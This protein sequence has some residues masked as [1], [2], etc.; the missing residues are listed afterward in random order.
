MH[1]ISGEFVLLLTLKYHKT[2][3][4]AER[5]VTGLPMFVSKKSLYFETRWDTLR[6]RRK[7]FKL[8]TMFKTDRNYLIHLIILPEMHIII[9]YRN[10]IYN[11]IKLYMFLLLYKNEMN[12]HWMLDEFKIF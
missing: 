5:I 8:K 12:F 11:Y 7:T 9:S 3:L 4:V 2:Q 1:L 10:V 6:N